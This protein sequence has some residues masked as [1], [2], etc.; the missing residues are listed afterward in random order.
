M[1]VFFYA[2]LTAMVALIATS[3]YVVLVATMQLVA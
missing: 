1:Q 3:A 2:V